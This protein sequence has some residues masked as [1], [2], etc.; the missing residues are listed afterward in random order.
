[1]CF[2]RPS[3]PAAP[4]PP[5]PPAPSATQLAPAV[6]PESR[7]NRAGLGTGQL[8]I[9]LRPAASALGAPGFAVGQGGASL[10]TVSVRSGGQT[11]QLPF[12]PPRR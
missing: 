5:P 2:S 1:M 8:T 7:R 9:P 6:S 11:V 3:A 12:N 10:P 4:P